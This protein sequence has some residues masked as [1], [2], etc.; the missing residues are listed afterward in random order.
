MKI[1]LKLSAQYEKVA[2]NN[3][4]SF[5][6]PPLY[7]QIRT[8]EALKNYPLVMNTYNTGTGKTKASLLHLFAL[9]GQKD[10]NVLFIAPTNELLHQHV[11][12]IEEFVQENDLTF[13][14][15]EI[16]A[17]LLKELASEDLV[18]RGGERLTRLLRNPQAFS[19]KLGIAPT[20][21]EKKP[22]ILVTNPDL[23]YYAFFWQ[24][25][26]ADQ[27]NLFEV[28]V[29]TFRYI[30]IDEFHY[31]NSKQMAN[32]LFFM[33]LSKEWG[34]FEKAERRLCLL[35][36]T[37]D[38]T[39]QNYLDLVFNP[40][41]WCL[42]APSTEP[43]EADIL[44]QI[45]VLAPLTLQ[46]EASIMTEF[47]Q[48][49][50]A[51]IKEWLNAGQHG[52]MISSALWKVNSAYSI[53]HRS[54]S[55]AE[56]RLGRITGAQP[57]KE[58]RQDQAKDLI[59]ATPT[60]DIG[61]NFVKEGKSRQNLDF[62]IFDARFHDEFVQRLGRAGRVLGKS[63]TDIPST[64]IALV[65]DDAVSA[66]GNLDGQTVTRADLARIL[67]D[68]GALPEK[69]DFKAYI[70]SGGMLENV[71]PIFQ[72]R[73]M[74][75]KV[76]EHILQS[77]FDTVKSVFAPN[78]RFSYGTMIGCYKKQQ[79]I[80]MLL[81]NKD[82]LKDQNKLSQI[83]ADFLGWLEGER[84]DPQ[85]IKPHLDEFL[86]QPAFNESL[87]AFCQMHQALRKAQFSFRDSFSGPTAL[88]YDR[89]KQLSGA[90]V[91]EYDLI[92]IAENY[93]FRFLERE[94]FERVTGK[95]EPKRD[96]YVQIHKQREQRQRINLRWAP[97]KL[98]HNPWTKET[99]TKCFA[100]G[101]PIAV[102]GL[103]MSAEEP[104]FEELC[105]AIESVSIPALLVPESKRGQL[106]REIRHR[107]VY[108]RNLAVDLADER[109]QYKAILG[110]NALLMAPILKW[111]FVMWQKAE[112]TAII[113]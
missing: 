40:D 76:E 77:L 63:E 89:G 41:G 110:T 112:E 6:H 35:S 30:V 86:E 66:L 103:R 15:I 95:V 62:V 75:S 38:S 109:V 80:S 65:N 25:S 108:T 37:P 61:Y 69:D 39:T 31:Y 24:F 113:C 4:Y 100:S 67:A 70:T 3:P 1:E 34:Y 17:A 29:R 42:I 57:I 44:E 49:R 99:F 101:Q 48:N 55:D 87:R 45:P 79:S 111:R 51:I 20:D 97:T 19:D 50:H 36:A 68:S 52:A 96:F 84:P 14:V 73:T 81:N 92:H 90:E 74:F 107:A 102:Q 94:E 53:L 33:I 72:L 26:P 98:L 58:R 46:I 18:N 54:L 88:V 2:A 85:A 5:D 32:F 60:V 91:T 16:N 105:T 93:D 47:T 64:A 22:L 71:Y 43:P 104:L 83:V 9:D 23:F 8:A 11:R 82:G 21:H 12:D 28:F 13:R 56:K 7:H 27:R 78:S 10:A 106:F 59:L